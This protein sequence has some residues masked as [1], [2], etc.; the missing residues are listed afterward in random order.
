MCYLFN[1]EQF[2]NINNVLNTK[3]MTAKCMLQFRGTRETRKKIEICPG[4]SKDQ[5]E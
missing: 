5:T 2:I 4:V 3:K 1:A